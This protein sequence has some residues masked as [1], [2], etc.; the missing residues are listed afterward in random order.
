VFH[1]TQKK[2]QKLNKE[3]IVGII[4]GKL[5]KLK[6]MFESQ[7]EKLSTKAA[8]KIQVFVFELERNILNNK[9]L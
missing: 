3:K 6:V 4:G 8:I 7:E 1:K 2:I 5:D 9:L